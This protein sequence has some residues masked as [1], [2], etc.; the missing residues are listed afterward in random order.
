[1]RRASL[2]LMIASAACSV[3]PVAW[4]EPAIVEAPESAARL[5]IG[6]DGAPAL[7]VGSPAPTAWEA[8]GACA[9]SVRFAR[10]A[11]AEVHAVWWQPR[12]GGSAAL[13]A[14]RSKDGGLSWEP[15]VPVDTLDGA[16][17][18]C[19]RPAPAITVDAITRYVHVAYFLDGP[20]GP[21]VFFSHSMEGGSLYHAPVP[22][23]YGERPSAV[24]IASDGSTVAIA[25]QDPNTSAPRVSVALSTT[26]GHLF[27]L[28]LPR[29]S[30]SSSAA[31]R[32]LVG[33]SGDRVAVAWLARPVNGVGD[34]VTMLRAGTVRT[35]E[36]RVIQ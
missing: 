21:G 13:L 1:M 24:D 22:I 20:Q 26:D 30:A 6:T 2:I 34:G 33:V 7:T 5:V 16:R 32:P 19:G 18:G 35:I 28:R 9:G 27:E 17:L 25:F 29:I 10:G 14:S 11:G 8:E 15:V 23:V 12:E 4:E 36:G 3:S 31:E